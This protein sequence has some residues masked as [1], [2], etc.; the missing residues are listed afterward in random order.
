[1]HQQLILLFRPQGDPQKLVNPVLF[2]VPHNNASASQ[3]AGYLFGLLLLVSSKYKVSGRG[4]HIEIQPLKLLGQL[5]ATANYSSCG[6]L[7]VV[8]IIKLR[9]NPT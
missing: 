1:M 4:Q 5:L 3:L 9:K 2:K 6:F 8:L 7:K